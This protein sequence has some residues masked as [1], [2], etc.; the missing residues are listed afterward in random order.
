[1]TIHE[2]QIDDPTQMVCI[3]D[4]DPYRE[5][6]V[7]DVSRLIEVYAIKFTG[8]PTISAFEGVKHWVR[9]LERK[10]SAC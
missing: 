10:L 8:N 5:L 2:P 7:T 4:V 9:V 6:S 3:P 1:M